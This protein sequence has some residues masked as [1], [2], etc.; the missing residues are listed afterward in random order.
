MSRE[1]L[2]RE[3][4]LLVEKGFSVENGTIRKYRSNKSHIGGNFIRV[5]NSETPEWND[6]SESFDSLSLESL[7]VEL[8]SEE[9][10]GR[11]NI[12][13]TYGFTDQNVTDFVIETSCF[14]PHLIVGTEK[15]ADWFLLATRLGLCCGSL[16]Q[17]DTNSQRV[18]EFAKTIH[19]E[20]L[21]EGITLAKT[22]MKRATQI[23]P[24]CDV[25]NDCSSGYNF[26]FVAN[27]I[28][29][30]ERVAFIVFGRKC[31]RQYYDRVRGTANLLSS[32][33]A[34]LV[35]TD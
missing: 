20:N 21:V 31:V 35:G 29:N 22:G 25:K 8:S 27:K 6:L 1:R 2:K 13:K 23:S 34:F 14:K 33:R 16:Q 4:Q 32:G 15:R 9:V 3:L 18:N 7:S 10:S 5:W 19:P 24:H 12:Q 30:D 17:M 11:G 26:L 28:V